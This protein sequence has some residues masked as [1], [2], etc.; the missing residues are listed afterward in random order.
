MGKQAIEKKK[1]NRQQAI[2]SIR[3]KKKEKKNQPERTL[4]R[5]FA[6]AIVGSQ[7]A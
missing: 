4:S 6:G 7:E 3:N 1:R 5:G 2:E